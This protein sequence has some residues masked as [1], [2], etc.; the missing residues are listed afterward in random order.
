MNRFDL[1]ELAVQSPDLEV[2][3]LRAVHGGEPR[4]LGEDFCGPGSLSR[5]WVRQ[6]PE[7]HAACVDLDAEPIEHARR[8]ARAQLSADAAARISYHEVDVRHCDVEVD[9][10][11]ALNFAACEFH[12][13][14]DLLAWLGNARR[15]L[16][17]ARGVLVADLYGGP[18]ALIP[19][20]TVMH[21]E[22][23]GG[24]G[25]GVMYTWA[26]DAVDPLTGRVRNRI[27]FELPDGTRME[28][29]FRYDWR[30]W[31]VPELRDAMAEAGFPSTSVYTSYGDAMDGDG[32]LLIREARG[33]D[34]EDEDNWV[35]YV[36]GR[37]GG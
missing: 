1:Y 6:L 23:D 36:V 17:A 21:I 34:L 31:T 3:F 12:A 8:R 13:R 2:R 22:M 15:R 28:G 18:G 20:D 10:I 4:R 5:A 7:G 30:L 35:A 16:E 14:A 33:Q 32:N 9:V 29:A 25:P 27:H 11:A 24:D 19:G 37:T 26:Q